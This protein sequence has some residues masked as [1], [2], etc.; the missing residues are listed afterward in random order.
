MNVQASERIPP[1]NEWVCSPKE[2]MG[3]GGSGYELSKC[4]ISKDQLTLFKM[5]LGINYSFERSSA[6][7]QGQF[8]GFPARK[9]LVRMFL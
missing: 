6:V 3:G 7:Q 4:V 8:A 1:E 9:A 5:G 2:K